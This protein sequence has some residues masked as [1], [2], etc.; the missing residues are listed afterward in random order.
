VDIRKH[1]GTAP[2]TGYA[3]LPPGIGFEPKDEPLRRDIN[4]LGRVLGQVLIEQEGEEL[5]E[6]E[7]E[8]RLLCKRLRFDYDPALD[9]R[10]RRKIEVLD[11]EQLRQ[12]VRAFS[13][14]FQ[15][16]NIAERYHRIRRRR[17]Y[18]SSLSDPPQRASLASA[19]TRLEREGFGAERLRRV[20]DGMSVGLVLTAHPTEAMR[21]SVRR[22][23]VA[24]GEML[25]LLES[26][27]LTWK[28]RRRLEEKLAEEVTVLWQTDELRARR[29]EVTQEIERTLLFF[30]NPLISA[31]LDVYREFEDELA[32]RFPGEAP[33][34]GRVLAFG[35]WVGGDQDG[36]PFVKPETL[37]AALE[38]HRQLILNRHLSS[39]LWLVNHMSQ[40]ARLI[41]VSEELRAS[42]A[43]DEKSLP[44]TAERY[45]CLDPNE[46]YRRKLLFVAERLRRTLEGPGTPAAY[47]GVRDFVEDL[48]SVRRSLLTHGGERTA[49]GS[50][51]DLIRQAEVFGFHL[52]KL[53]VRQESSR[54]VAAVA[55]L[56]AAGTSEDL[57]V[58]TEGARASLLRR[59]VV[60]PAPLPPDHDGLSEDSREVLDTFERI[61][62]ARDAFSEPPIETFILSMAHQASDVLC[63]Q[64]LARRAG[65]LEVNQSGR[66]TANHL[67]ITPLFETIE[68]LDRASDV[69]RRLL[70]DPFYRS[71]LSRLDDLQEIMLG[72]SDSGKD[73]GYV[74]SNWVLYKAQGSL[75]SVAGEHGVRLRLFHGRGG[76]AGRGGGPSYQ[77]IMAQPPGTL[78]GRIRITE[79]GEVISFKYSMRGLARRNLDTVLAAVLE[80]SATADCS[81]GRPDARWV[82]AMEELS[83]KA[84]KTYRA[85]VYDDEGFLNFFSGASPIVELSMLNM[86]SRPARRVQDP[87]VESL[88]AIPWVFAWT[89]NRFL[90]PSWYGAG[91]ALEDY[92]SKDSGLNL[93]RE[94]YER[95]PFF[96]TLTDFMQMTLAKS[97][98][99]IAETYVSLVD[100]AELRERLWRRI[101]DEHA[102]CVGALL[103]VT[104]HE[105]LL[106]DSPVLQR[107]IRLRNPYVDPLSYVQVNLLRR[108]RNL[109]E[110]S[111][112]RE[113]TLNTLLLT[114]SG[115]SSGMLNT[116]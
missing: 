78:D 97:D 66:C 45:E 84:Q 49:N 75:A 10:L 5:F 65:L 30:E 116:G 111:P 71:S 7:E 17:Q 110:G 61:R 76:S 81:A 92:A 72:Y 86:G 101:F 105:N 100:N 25:E 12:I 63:V 1:L 85:L 27:P 28:E 54:V 106:D 114:I 34:L 112:E 47:P 22:K 32:R 29:P 69:L 104:G 16:V 46:L 87:E 108:L 33:E 79:Q 98:L 90:L 56:L 60:D 93:L 88:R 55:E 99:R 83:D 39:V 14:Y 94:M 74:T 82:E 95:W 53:D 70:E 102:A 31:T 44:E 68:D 9:E 40:S 57:R 52:A 103:K 77:A 50:L 89:Q 64:L 67:R 13:V 58:M 6:T 19:L 21:R 48:N 96:R 73:A 8:V 36:N 11:G 42:V 37:S 4:L 24:I 15:L 43:R 2:E 3:D 62:Q 115:I 113:P 59:L 41:G 107:S 20:L 18:E 91:S 80:S 35:S 23:H 51:R 26:G 109:P 38:L